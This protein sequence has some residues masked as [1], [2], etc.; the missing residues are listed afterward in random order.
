MLPK[1]RKAFIP[2]NVSGT[3]KIKTALHSRALGLSISNASRP[4]A[5]LL[6]DVKTD[7]AG[8]FAFPLDKLPENFLQPYDALKIEFQELTA[9]VPAPPVFIDKAGQFSE[10]LL[11]AAKAP[12]AEHD[13]T[14]TV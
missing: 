3:L 13:F 6:A 1:T 10:L 5:A 8:V 7:K 4:G 14:V 9:E 2:E 12:G 11:V